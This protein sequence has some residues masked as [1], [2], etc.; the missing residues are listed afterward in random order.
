MWATCDETAT[1]QPVRVRQVCLAM[2]GPGRVASVMLA[3][4]LAGDTPADHAERVACVQAACEALTCQAGQAAGHAGSIRLLQALIPPADAW[5]SRTLRDAG[6]IH[7]GELA[8]LRRALRPVLPWVD[9]AWPDGIRVRPVRGVRLGEPDRQA[10]LTAMERSYVRTLD[11][12]ELCGL[13][14]TA[15]ILDSHLA[16]GE[17][18]PGLWFLVWH[19][20]EPHGCMLLSPCPARGA[21]EL[22]YLGLSESL[23][24]CGLGRRL[25]LLGLRVAAR[26]GLERMTCAVD[27]RNT[28]ARRLYQRM[29]FIEGVHRHA[30]VR[31]LEQDSAGI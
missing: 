14:E 27:T 12:P 16:A 1:G 29:G 31:P 11:C 21:V 26:T 4:P 24:G 18:D 10:M 7:V 15:D 22:V 25:M 28:P 23:R 6:F 5:A 19:G 3:P 17:H 8:Y 2:P 13:R 9:E 20:H 30:L